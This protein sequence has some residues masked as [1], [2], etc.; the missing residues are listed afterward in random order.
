[1]Y[2]SE[3]NNGDS[4]TVRVLKKVAPSEN[5]AIIPATSDREFWIEQR[6]ALLMQLASIER[7][8]GLFTQRCRVCKSRIESDSR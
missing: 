1:M 7:R 5:S 4:A 8:L 3:T 6:H 2:P